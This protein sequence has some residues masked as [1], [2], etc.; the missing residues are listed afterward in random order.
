MRPI[1]LTISAFGSYAGK[2]V[3]EMDKFG[4]SGLY[5]ITG[6]TGAGKT[7]IFDAITFALYGKT[8]GENREP[9]M[10][11]SKY[12]DV[13]TP[14]EVELVFFYKEK[15]YTVRRN[16]EYNR[17]KT[18]GE[19]F[20][21]QKAE[22]ELHYPDGRV[23]TK[24]K[25]VDNVIRDI[26][27]IDYGQF[28]QIAMI[29]QGDFLK[30]L[31]APTEERQKIFRQI[32]YTKLYQSLQEKLKSEAQDLKA[33]CDGVRENIKQHISEITVDENNVLSIE[34]NKAKKGTLPISDTV[35]LLGE[36]IRQD[37]LLEDSL[38]KKIIEADNKLAVVNENLGK[39][40]AHED[41]KK[42]LEVAEKDYSAESENLV[43]LKKILDEETAKKSGTEK[44]E[45][46][47]AK[48]ES[49]FPRYDD[50]DKLEKE[51]KSLAAKIKKQKQKIAE[52]ASSLDGEIQV[53][54]ELK[55]ELSTLS[56][57]GE[58]KERL[59]GKKKTAEDQQNKLKDIC[60]SL[61]KYYEKTKELEIL[62]EEY[63]EI[64]KKAEEAKENYDAKN[65]AFLD[66]QAGIIAE[67]L[68]EGK[69]CPV[70]GSLS[71][72]T[73]AKKSEGA[74]SE[75]ELKK[76]K[77]N[78]DSAQKEAEEKSLDCNSVE[79]A[80]KTQ[81]QEI[82]RQIKSTNLNISFEDAG[83]F[84]E[85]EFK[86]LSEEI[87]ALSSEIN[88]ETEK[89]ERKNLLEKTIPEKESELEILKNSIEEKK[90]E[91]A[92]SEA[93]LKSKKEQSDKEKSKLSFECKKEAEAR[94]DE[95]Q[96]TI[97]T[98][99]ESLKNAEE[100]YNKSDKKKGELRAVI[101]ESKKQ[102]STVCNLNKEEEERKKEELS[103]IKNEL[104]RQLKD[105]HL[106]IAANKSALE[107]II[108][109]SG[110][111][112]DYE[113]RYQWVLPLSNTANGKVAGKEKVMLETYIQMTY[114]DRIISRANTRFMVMSGG[115]YELKRRKE[116]EDKKAQSG[117][118]L[119]IIDHYNGTERSVKTLSGGESFKASL[120]LALGLSDEIQSTSG[121]IKLDTMFVDEGFG[122]LDD[123]SIDQAMNA[124]S[125][126]AE[127]NRLVGIIS[128]VSELKNRIDKQIVVT[129]EKSGGS[130]AN[131]MT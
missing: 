117:L 110:D 56:N 23:V 90:E 120:S 97:R 101:D 86:R 13:D 40:K 39:I 44:A 109:K 63:K 71:H 50:I 26:M 84:I 52:N 22:A 20:T 128:H 85:R 51:I 27:G 37:S 68:E 31:L 8:S 104:G 35:I 7:T 106:H 107:K 118:D 38:N 36:L 78:A 32:F 15:I 122:N 123:D 17:P 82:E 113:K 42:R 105:L 125:G 4:S 60:D 130:M 48:I 124:L 114:F 28:L 24:P 57:A 76:A 53:A 111:L 79:S 80:L 112:D 3:L 73:P 103:Q 30:L 67:R 21:T 6:D 47:K 61:D 102:L 11:R 46:E 129:K 49:E 34:V 9:F 108:S 131:I 83:G 100:N 10:L 87:S 77:F 115:Q 69:P 119:D 98:N 66:E 55:K 45:K 88:K 64:F 12:A 91:A 89:K 18:R 92:E 116:A 1:K 19:G 126:L 95:L 25:D 121:G 81:K 16:P 54:D 75:K 41:A 94:Y 5:L 93:D 33:Q 99:K 59:L 58:E 96:R 127:G 70:C 29:A 14:T 72:P 74:P 2:T 65:K 43:K 62:Q